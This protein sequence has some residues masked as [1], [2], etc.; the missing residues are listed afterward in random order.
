VEWDDNLGRRWHV[1]PG[2][3]CQERVRLHPD[4]IEECDL[5]GPNEELGDFAAESE[6][7]RGYVDEELIL[8]MRAKIRAE[9]N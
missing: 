8:A 3:V 2:V 6:E 9:R 5:P 1:L 7:N 4:D